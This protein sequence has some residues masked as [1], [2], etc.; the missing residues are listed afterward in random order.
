MVLVGGLAWAGARIERLQAVIDSAPV[1]DHQGC[2]DRLAWCVSDAHAAIILRD[3]ADKWDN[4]E[5]MKNIQ[6][7]MNSRKQGDPSVTSMWLR[8]QADSQAGKAE[9]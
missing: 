7:L 8:E 6:R 1:L 3:A 5:E 2:V 4:V 9:P